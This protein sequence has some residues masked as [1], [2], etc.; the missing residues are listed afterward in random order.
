[1]SYLASKVLPRIQSAVSKTAVSNLT[2]TITDINDFVGFFAELHAEPF[3]LDGK[4]VITGLISVGDTGIVQYLFDKRD[5][6][7]FV[8]FGGRRLLNVGGLSNH[9]PNMVLDVVVLTNTAMIGYTQEE[10]VFDA[11]PRYEEGGSSTVW[12]MDKVVRRKVKRDESHNVQIPV[13]FNTA[14]MALAK[15]YSQTTERIFNMPSL[16][17][18]RGELYYSLNQYL[19]NG[20]IAQHSLVD[21]AKLGIFRSVFEKLTVVEKEV[22]DAISLEDQLTRVREFVAWTKEQVKQLLT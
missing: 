7:L 15:H 18:Y 6:T 13:N 10:A 22:N 9:D 4:D 11:E 17:P 2:A 19:S 1:M 8:L 14:F 12:V 5:Q 16:S 3:S 20:H 21:E